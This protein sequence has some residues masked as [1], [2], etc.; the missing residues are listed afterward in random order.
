MA[1]IGMGTPAMA[2]D[3]RDKKKV[4][5][6]LLVDSSKQT[7]KA[8]GLGRG[9]TLEV[10]GPRVLARGL[11]ALAKGQMQGLTIRQDPL[12][13]GGAVVFDRGGRIKLVHRAGDSADN[14]PVQMLLD[15][16]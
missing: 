4:P 11:K 2:A 15:A 1:A 9:S 3:F 14:L 12:Q 7:Y 5:F 16:L 13:L 8:L 10:A 6:P